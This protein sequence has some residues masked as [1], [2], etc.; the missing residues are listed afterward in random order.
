MKTSARKLVAEIAGIVERSLNELQKF[1]SGVGRPGA[2]LRLAIGDLRAHIGAYLRDGSF[3]RRLLICYR[4]ATE[5]GVTVQWMDNVLKQL[6][7][8][9]PTYLP[10]VLVVQNSCLFALAQ[11]ARILNKTEFKSREDVQVMLVRMKNWF[12]VTKELAA[13]QRDNPSYAAL[14][15]LGGTITRYLADVARPLPRMLDYDFTPLPALALSQ[16][17]YFEGSRAE[18]IAAENR[19]VHPAF[20]PNHIRALSA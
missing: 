19:V 8:E 13:E 6:T 10:S 1:G 18:E 17:I 3:G 11:D 14:I 9:T 16:L 15:N 2:D 5:A 20:C 12:D 4:A 7:S